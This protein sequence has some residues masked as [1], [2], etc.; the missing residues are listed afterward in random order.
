MIDPGYGRH[1]KRRT[2]KKSSSLKFAVLTCVLTLS[3]FGVAVYKGRIVLDESLFSWS[4]A[5]EVAD[6]PRM[7]DPN[8]RA[9]QMRQNDLDKQPA[10]RGQTDDDPTVET[11]HEPVEDTGEEPV[12]K[13]GAVNGSSG[14][15]EPSSGHRFG[16][17]G[18]RSL[19][20]PQRP[21]EEAVKRQKELARELF[22]ERYSAAKTQS[23]RIA[24]AKSIFLEGRKI[25]AD[26]AATFA[27]SQ[28]ASDM[29]AIEGEFLITLGIIDYL[30]SEYAGVD[31]TSLKA[32]ALARSISAVSAPQLPILVRS[33]ANLSVECCREGEIETAKSLIARVENRL[34][35]RIGRQMSET[36]G[37]IKSTISRFEQAEQQYRA[38]L[39]TIEQEPGSAQKN[40]DIGRYLALYCRRWE[41]GIECLAK[42]S[43]ETIRDAAMSEQSS[44]SS[45]QRGINVAEAW[46][47]AIATIDDPIAQES[48]HQHA[49]ELYRQAQTWAKGLEK[50]I[51]ETR[52]N[53]LST[54]SHSDSPAS[55]GDILMWMNLLST[56]VSTSGRRRRDFANVNDREFEIGMGSGADGLGEAQVGFELKGVERI[57]VEGRGD[58][59]V[60]HIDHSS[61]CGFFIDYSTPAGFSK[62]VFLGLSLHPGRI[63]NESPPW[64]TRTT[65]PAVVTDIGR[66]ARY[67]IDLKRWA[68]ANWD[69]RC[70]FTVNMQ[71]AG[72]NRTLTGKLTWQ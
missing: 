25:E 19:I 33:V 48:V 40:Y 17:G 46:F 35:N 60:A 4:S 61:K 24:L 43:H 42:S 67:Q 10:N 59:A 30:A 38:A 50:Q 63:F 31:S 66:S 64:G 54:E 12:N 57:I 53:E 51:V 34:G 8:S 68:P 5:P 7:D 9:R 2:R 47:D 70:W 37:D 36:L 21:S 62:R 32:D 27:L 72:P 20:H 65:R 22:E 29:L 3:L 26:P 41:Q 71:N 1:R 39:N 49:L 56:E 15:N 52:I 28:I 16:D 18:L 14:G 13:A 55:G 69:G 58:L 23:E 45:L 44:R 11:E 6:V